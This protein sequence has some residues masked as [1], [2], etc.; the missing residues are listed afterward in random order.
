MSGNSKAFTLIELIITLAVL[1]IF[2]LIAIPAFN[3]ML[4]NHRLSG[5]IDALAAGLN[6][7]RSTALSLSVPTQVCPYLASNS[8]A[9]GTSW[10]NGWIAITA[11][12]S[13]SST[14]IQSHPALSQLLTLTSSAGIINF[15][16][17]GL[18]SSMS[19]FKLC[20]PRGGSFARSA[21]VQVTGMIQVGATPGVAVWDNGGLTCP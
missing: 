9:C 3:T 11:P 8:T 7:A 15:D 21:M 5:E 14:L 13:G 6:S 2:L 20:D 12:T 17:H 4:M 18:A 16:T 1:S 19:N 10:N